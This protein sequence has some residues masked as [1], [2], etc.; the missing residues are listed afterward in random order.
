[1]TCGGMICTMEVLC[2]TVLGFDLHCKL[3]T[4]MSAFLPPFGRRP[5]RCED[6]V[7]ELDPEFRI[8][9]LPREP[10]GLRSFLEQPKERIRHLEWP[11]AMATRRK[12]KK[13]ALELARG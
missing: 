1:M 5:L 11:A 2:R 4:S 8:Y 7:K 3:A 13:T 6:L 12:L 9:V 10:H